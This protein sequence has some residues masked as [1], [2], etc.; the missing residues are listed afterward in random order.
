M[1]SKKATKHRTT[2][3]ADSPRKGS[4]RYRSSTITGV[5]MIVAIAV[6]W[7]L[8]HGRGNEETFDHSTGGGATHALSSPESAQNLIGRWQ[9]MDA[10]YVIEVRSIARDGAVDAAYFN[11]DPIHVSKALAS[12]TAGGLDLFVEL[13]D[14]GYPGATYVLRYNPDHDVLVGIYHQPTAGQDFEV[15][16]KRK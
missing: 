16:F 13:M 9:R 1:T 7:G 14:V 2:T 11:P 12:D 10:G 5:V 4:G 15:A 6:W 8:T 3:R